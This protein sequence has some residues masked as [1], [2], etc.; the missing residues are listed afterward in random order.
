MKDDKPLADVLQHLIRS[1]PNL[2]AL[3][4]HG[5]LITAPFNANPTAAQES[6]PFK[7][8]IYPTFF[9]IRGVPYGEVFERAINHRMR[10]TFETNARDDY[11]LSWIEGEG[12]PYLIDKS[13]NRTQPVIGPKLRRAARR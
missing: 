6:T 13:G 9:K 1:S 3:L 2:T 5:Q 4:Q 8:E 10:L 7:G 12:S 11:F